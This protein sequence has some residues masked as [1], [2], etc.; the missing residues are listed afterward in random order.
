[1]GEFEKIMKEMKRRGIVPRIHYEL[2]ALRVLKVVA[3]ILVISGVIWMIW[4]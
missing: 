2:L 4:R 3:V 1:M